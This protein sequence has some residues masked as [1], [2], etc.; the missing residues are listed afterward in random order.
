MKLETAEIIIPPGAPLP[1][2][3]QG[4]LE[5]YFVPKGEARLRVLL[6][7]P[8]NEDTRGTIIIVPGRTEF[9]E[10]YAEVIS[11]FIVRNFVVCVI[12]HRGQG[13]SSRP[14]SD[15][16]KSHIKSFHIYADDL[17]HIIDTLGKRLPKPHIFLA[18]S[19]G[20]CIALHSILSGTTTPSAIICSAPMLGL[21]DLSSRPNKYLIK[22]L[23]YMG[24]SGRSVPYQQQKRGLP[25]AFKH[26]KLT[27][28]KTRFMRWAAYFTNVPRLRVAGPT[29]GWIASAI[30][31]MKF[32][33]RNAAQL[34]TPALIVGAGGDPIVD[35]ASNQSFAERAGAQY[36]VIPGALHEI[37]LERDIYR[38][39]MFDEIDSFLDAQAL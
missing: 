24:L 16:L 23:A 38:E 9:C 17:G 28:D 29:F 31:G 37:F 19:M 8:D 1:D 6:A 35:P 2:T 11:D 39:V 12:D 26:N 3:L 14:L 30:D 18:H 5:S 13:L 25:V 10:K 27:S 22:L 20:G 33:N 32:V 15:P 21:F 34:K 36:T 7:R 4:R